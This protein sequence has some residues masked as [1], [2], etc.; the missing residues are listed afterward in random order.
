MIHAEGRFKCAGLVRIFAEVY[1]VEVC[2]SVSSCTFLIHSAATET[3]SVAASVSLHCCYCNLCLRFTL[4]SSNSH[5]IL[6]P[7]KWFI[8]LCR[9]KF[10][11]LFTPAPMHDGRAWQTRNVLKLIMAASS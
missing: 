11:C 3:L 9:N 5:I 2:H 1:P 10:K 7:N 4:R 8:R 6:L